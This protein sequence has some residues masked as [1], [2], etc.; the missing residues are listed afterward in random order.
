[1]MVPRT[2][3][4]AYDVWVWALS[5]IQGP[6]SV[7]PCQTLESR[8]ATLCIAVRGVTLTSRVQ[9]GGEARAPRRRRHTHEQRRRHVRGRVLLI[10]RRNKLPRYDFRREHLNITPASSQR[11]PASS[12]CHPASS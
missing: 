9:A 2:K 10:V 12:L 1:M 8:F 6:F 5:I 11:H 4:R 7:A 3:G